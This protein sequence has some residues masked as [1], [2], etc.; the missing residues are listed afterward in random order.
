MV[1]S[2][3]YQSLRDLGVEVVLELARLADG[4]G[5]H[6]YEVQVYATSKKVWPFLVRMVSFQVDRN[7]RKNLRQQ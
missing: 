2:V 6:A 4:C 3:F 1:C 5:D 7:K